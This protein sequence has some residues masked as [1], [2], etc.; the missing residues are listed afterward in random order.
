MS[1][2]CFETNIVTLLNSYLIRI[3]LVI[4]VN[5]PTECEIKI[6]TLSDNYKNSHVKSKS[7]HI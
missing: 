1:F 2:F 4:T 5:M 7:G 6:I 3:V